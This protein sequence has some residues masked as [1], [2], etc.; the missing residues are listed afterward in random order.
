LKQASS[1]ESKKKRKNGKPNNILELIAFTVK[2]V[3][4]G[5]K[6]DIN[7]IAECEIK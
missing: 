3:G 6:Q 2:Y 4:Q 1:A 7:Y 5:M